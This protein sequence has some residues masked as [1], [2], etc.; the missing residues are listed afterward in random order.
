MPSLLEDNSLI[1]EG[2]VNFTL[3]SEEVWGLG[4]KF[5]LLGEF[6]VSLFEEEILVDIVPNVI[7]MTWSKGCCGGAGIANRLDMFLM[8]KYLCDEMGNYHSY[9]YYS[10]IFYH[11]S[12][13]L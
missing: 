5:D 9:S 3:S 2:D 10:S 7:L 8:Y 11:N 1:L 4:N 13:I 12:V 6:L